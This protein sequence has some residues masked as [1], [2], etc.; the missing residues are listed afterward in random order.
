MARLRIMSDDELK[1]FLAYELKFNRDRHRDLELEWGVC[2]RIYQAVSGK[3]QTGGIDSDS[4]MR[5]L[6]Q[7]SANTSGKP[8]LQSTM[9][10]RAMFF[11]HS[12]LCITEPD[13]VARPFKR[14]WE[15]KKAA[16]CGQLWVE[17]IKR[18]TNL[19]ETIESGPYLNAVTKGNGIAYIGWDRHAGDPMLPE[20]FN[21][22]S[23]EFAMS[24][25]V[26]VRSVS[27]RDFYIDSTAKHFKD[28]KCCIERMT[29]SAQEF[30]YLYPDKKD[31]LNNLLLK[32]SGYGDYRVESGKKKSKNSVDVYFYWERA[33]P[34][35]GMLGSYV[36]FVETAEQDSPIE[37][38]ERKEHPFAHKELP[39]S[40]I[41]DLDIDENPYGMSRAVHCAHHLDVVNLFLSLIIE[42]VEICGVPRVVA[43]EGSTDDAIKV[44][45]IAKIVYYNP[46]SGGQIYH[47]KPSAIVT[48]VW[49]FI[50][51]M[52]SEID[53]IYGQGEFS[54]GEI[55]RELSSYAVQLAIE[56][57]DKY[58]IRLFNKK[59]QF[60][61]TIYNH[62]LSLV[63]QFCTEPRKLEVI[64]TENIYKDEFF[65]AEDTVGDYGIYVEYGKY[66]PIDPAA[67]KQML[68]EI[69]N[70][71]AYERAG[72]NLRKIFKLLLDGDMFDLTEVFSQAVRTQESEIVDLIEGS[73]EVAVMPWQEHPAHM[74][75][76]QDVFQTQFFE[77]L[78]PEHKKILWEHYTQ[79]EN[80][81]AKLEAAAAKAQNPE[82]AGGQQ[83]GQIA[84]PQPGTPVEAG[85]AGAMPQM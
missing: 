14:D 55:P 3:L 16:E 21:P 73:R 39:Y 61:N 82:A 22:L 72:G 30:I 12:K 62:A 17:H 38:L 9:L 33:L 24:G 67:R 15:T 10:A 31:I 29:I 19:Q 63:Q 50:D 49:R 46:A 23:D 35:N 56:M 80:E 79:H 81:Q 48:D 1:D 44:A 34:W 52:R 57:D 32:D 78:E 58:R 42:N 71:G 40:I 28:A 36:V 68:L 75:A 60:L 37:I 77:R 69:V 26:T 66:M 76:L 25:E 5:E 64:G 83:G 51:L 70:N 84:M 54:R 47:L 4:V 45:D 6:L 13:V 65:M 2:E 74:E 20:N 11:L 27:P 8:V 18:V 59:R 85:G 41:T 53:A 7:T 43:P